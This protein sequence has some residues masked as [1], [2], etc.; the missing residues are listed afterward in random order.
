M[1]IN[2]VCIAKIVNIIFFK[3]TFY[4]QCNYTCVYLKEIKIKIRKNNSVETDR[5]FDKEDGDCSIKFHSFQ[6]SYF[7]K[8]SL[9]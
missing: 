8:L 6:D 1:N 3:E 2:S 7:S 4:S 9:L 5:N